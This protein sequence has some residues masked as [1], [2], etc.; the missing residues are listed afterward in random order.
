MISAFTLRQWLNQISAGVLQWLAATVLSALA[1]IFLLTESNLLEVRFKLR[2]FLQA[3]GA[4]EQPADPSLVLLALFTKT[5][6]ESSVT[7]RAYLARLVDAVSQYQPALIALDY[8]FLEEDRSDPDF[9]KLEQALARAGRVVLPSTLLRYSGQ[10]EIASL[11]PETLRRYCAVGYATLFEE[12]V[13]NMALLTQLADRQLVPSFVATIVAG[14]KFPN[15]IFPAPHPTRL[16]SAARDTAHAQVNWPQTD[17]PDILRRLGFPGDSTAR[18]PINYLGPA[19][20][21]Q[22]NVFR[23]DKFLE[24]AANG[25]YAADYF[26]GKIVLIGSTHPLAD[27]SDRF[28]TPLGPM[29]G[30]EIHGQIINNLLAGNY[31]QPLGLG[32]DILFS[33]LAF[34]LAAASLLFLR[35]SRAVGLTLAAVLAY[36]ILGCILFINSGWILPLAYPLKAALVGFLLTYYL[37]QHGPLKVKI[38]EFLDF[39][40]LLTP[41]AMKDRYMVRV[42]HAPALAGDA[43]AEVTFD[44]PAALAPEASAAGGRKVLRHVA[45]EEASTLENNLRRLQRS[46]VDEAFLKSFGHDLHQHLFV[47]EVA[48]AYERSLTQ[49]RA[50]KKGLR[51]RL[52]LEAPQLRIIPWEYLFDRRQ[53]FF[54]AVNPEIL[55]TRYVESTQP[56]RALPVEQLNVLIVLSNP[57]PASLLAAGLSELDVH[58]EKNLIVAALRELDQR[59]EVRLRYTILEHAVP[60]EIRDHL[61][62][63]Y[64]VFHFIGHSTY[65]EG[66]GAIVLENA[67]HEAVLTGEEVFSELFLGNTDVRLVVLNSCKSGATSAL[68]EISGLAYRLIERGVPAIVAMQY[69]IADETAIRFAQEFYRALVDSRQVDFAM[70][71]ARQALA[72]DGNHRDAGIPVL[73]MRASDGRII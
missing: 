23:A 62:Q 14:Y 18:F 47:D 72:Q 59:G 44:Q 34:A 35:L 55:L 36:F 10:Y 3:V 53:N 42:I 37:Q 64:H 43:A 56:R 57:G 67:E 4:A 28:D 58:Y 60:D 68:P 15:E 19:G 33:I 6:R 66:A 40:L 48:A 29:F 30:V 11:P 38:K 5:A 45:L 26:R 9:A 16:D 7:P 12:K 22:M 41:A 17:W 39:E 21:K 50:E 46:A 20:R 8:E 1:A 13:H 70:A 24:H 54:L 52:R 27:G 25:D 65:R 73:Y 31:L 63:E 71:H 61:R 2:Y 51:L 32:W 69:P 49:A